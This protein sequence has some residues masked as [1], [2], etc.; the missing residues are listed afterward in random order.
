MRRRRTAARSCSI[1]RSMV[2]N[3]GIAAELGYL[4][5]PDGILLEPKQA[6]NLPDDKLVYM[7]TGQPG[8]ADG[9][10]RRGWRT[11]STR[12]RSARATR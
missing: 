3:M 11:S 6:A 9:G 12:S 7:S 1:G 8:R 4:Q 10:A 2:R 5:V